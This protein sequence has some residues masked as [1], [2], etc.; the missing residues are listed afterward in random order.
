MRTSLR[1][2]TTPS[3]LE[4]RRFKKL[5]SRTWTSHNTVSV[6]GKGFRIGTREAASRGFWV[7]RSVPYGYRKILARDVS[8]IRSKLEPYEDIALVVKPI[9]TYIQDTP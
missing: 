6:W 7:V 1:G 2:H 9:G 3:T 4:R 5:Q 8:R